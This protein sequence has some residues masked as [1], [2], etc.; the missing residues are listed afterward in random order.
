MPGASKN[1]L[2]SPLSVLGLQALAQAKRVEQCLS[3]SLACIQFEAESDQ[4]TLDSSSKSSEPIQMLSN[5][6]IP[7]V[8]AYKLRNFG[9]F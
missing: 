3:V 2:I 7:Y 4:V 6:N 9:H 8:L 1:S 5:V